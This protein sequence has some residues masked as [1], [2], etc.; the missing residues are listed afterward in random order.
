MQGVFNFI[1]LQ[2]DQLWVTLG[3]VV[4]VLPLLALLAWI[5]W[6]RQ[7]DSLW[8]WPSGCWVAGLVL[9]DFL[10]GPAVINNNL[11]VL[12]DANPMP[13]FHAITAWGYVLAVAG[14]IVG[15]YIGLR[16]TRKH[17]R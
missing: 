5:F 16:L 11:R 6:A 2:R 7:V 14:L 1:I 12:R 9:G 3:L 8:T 4:V 17:V 10:V 13:Y 15:L